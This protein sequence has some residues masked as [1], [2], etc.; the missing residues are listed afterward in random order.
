MFILGPGELLH[1]NKGRLHAF[2]K[3]SK[4][5]LPTRDCHFG[6]R[7]EKLKELEQ[8]G[9]LDL[10]CVSVA[11]DW[12]FLGDTPRTV[13]RELSTSLLASRCCRNLKMPCLGIPETS[14]LRL[15]Q[16]CS[17]HV[18]LPTEES[19]KLKQPKK[20]DTYSRRHFQA[21]GIQPS[22][23]Y[24]FQCQS[25]YLKA[26]SDSKESGSKN[27]NGA[28]KLDSQTAEID[29]FGNEGWTCACCFAELSNFYYH[30]TACEKSSSRSKDFNVCYD[31]HE[32]GDAKESQ[33]IHTHLDYRCSLYN[34]HIGKY[35]EKC[36]C[37]SSVCPNTCNECQKCTRCSC[38]CHSSFEL[39]CRF[40]C[41]A[42]IQFLDK[43]VK[44]VSLEGE[45][46]P[47]DGLKTA[48]EVNAYLPDAIK[49]I[50]KLAW[51]VRKPI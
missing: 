32:N 33:R 48:P 23:D 10:L 47:G 11:W 42:D 43:A 24:W 14:L 45:A 3:M 28:P 21:L 15:S 30:C 44:S 2:R 5:L 17:S 31:C 22:I 40:L 25:S 39:R 8:K 4:D 37:G 29:E 1:I 26:Q 7:K 38:I 13:N 27:R 50:D 16:I 35:P 19:K 36:Q 34:H 9:S 51:N 6:L 20:S 49:Q 18:V 46:V 12:M 41:Q